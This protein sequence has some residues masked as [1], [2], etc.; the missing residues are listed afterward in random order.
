MINARLNN[1]SLAPNYPE[2]SGLGYQVL[3]INYLSWTQK[4]LKQTAA[5]IPDLGTTSIVADKSVVWWSIDSHGQSIL[6]STCDNYK[7]KLSFVKY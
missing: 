2:L 4:E 6:S 7:N 5:D 1:S 3:V